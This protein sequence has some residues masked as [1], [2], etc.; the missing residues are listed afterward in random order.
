MKKTEKIINGVRYFIVG[1][2]LWVAITS[3]IQAF[4]CPEMTGMQKFLYIPESFV[5]NF[6]N[7]K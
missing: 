1:V 4:K 7:C 2:M 6:K 3:T 5:C